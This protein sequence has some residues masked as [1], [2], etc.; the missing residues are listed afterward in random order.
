[1]REIYFNSDITPKSLKEIKL[2]ALYYDKINIV[3]DAVYTP[4]FDTIDG[5]FKFTGVED[6]EFIPKS[7]R[8][9]YKLLIDENLIGIT[10]TAENQKDKESNQ[11]ASEISKIVNVNHDLIFPLH[12][13]DKEA[14]IITEEVYD[15]MKNMWDFEWGKPVETDLIWWYYSKKLQ[16]FIKLLID[17]KNCLSSSNN[18]NSLFA[19]FIDT[20][21]KS[22]HDLGTKGYN[23]SLAFDAL[24][25]N[26]PNPDL[27]SFEDILE[28]KLKLKDELGLFYQTINSIET[29]NKQ[30]FSTDIQNNEY[31]AIF[32]D[33]IQKPLRELEIKMKNLNSK[34]FR[35]F[36]DKM[37]NPKSYVPLVGT[38]VA[39]IPIQYS[40]LCSLGMTVGQSY[41]EYKEEK[42]E[43]TNNGLYFLLKLK[44]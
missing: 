37:Q 18:L 42:R 8:T 29:R 6:L 3:N 35:G 14:R 21:T 9:D 24:K 27:L 25:I 22:N 20:Y 11:F 44:N 26:L 34:T 15:V 2:L 40:I 7:F 41:L 36:I 39:S 17:G 43:V 12:P 30:L 23:K 5:E 10:E 1:M 19:S 4:K 16:W 32:Y 33:E 31:E 38:V 13:N 28:L